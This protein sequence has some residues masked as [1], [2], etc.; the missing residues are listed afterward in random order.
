M[1]SF[2][3]SLVLVHSPVFTSAVVLISRLFGA[4]YFY[5]FLY[6]SNNVQNRKHGNETEGYKFGESDWT[7]LRARSEKVLSTAVHTSTWS[8]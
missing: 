6:H 5:Y 3:I 1:Y 8:G 4:S 2:F 7:I